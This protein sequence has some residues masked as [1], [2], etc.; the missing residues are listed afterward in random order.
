MID[1]D[2]I[3]DIVRNRINV[4][5]EFGYKKCNLVSGPCTYVVLHQMPEIKSFADQLVI[6]DQHY[7][8]TTVRC[9]TMISFHH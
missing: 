4:N 3:G 5:I 1:N 8:D 2:I 7:T 6:T 9:G